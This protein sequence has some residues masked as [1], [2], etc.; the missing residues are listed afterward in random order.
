MTI[1]MIQATVM[2]IDDPG[3]DQIIAYWVDV[4]PGKGYVTLTCYGAAWT[5]YFGAMGGYTIQGFFERVDVGYMVTKMAAPSLKQGKR[6]DA[7]LERIVTTVQKAL[8]I[9]TQGAA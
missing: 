2:K 9:C 4:E 7:Y 1:T 5:A 3:I 6:H 8:L